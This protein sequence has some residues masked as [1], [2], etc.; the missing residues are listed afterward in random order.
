MPRAFVLFNVDSGSEDNV[1]QEL[2]KIEG[3]Q[4]VYVFYGAYDLIARV[5]ADT[6]E[7]LKDA[8]TQK[9]RIIKNVRATLTLIMME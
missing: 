8:I 7:K 3:I 9:V 6:M 4:E 5:K 2:K 1:L